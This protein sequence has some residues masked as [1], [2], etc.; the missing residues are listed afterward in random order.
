M[1]V[2]SL[3]RSLCGEG[4]VACIE[5]LDL[6]VNAEQTGE[7]FVWKLQE[8]SHRSFLTYLYEKVYFF[9]WF[10]SNCSTWA[11]TRIRLRVRSF[12][13]FQRQLINRLKCLSGIFNSRGKWQ[14]APLGQLNEQ[15]HVSWLSDSF[16][17]YR[18]CVADLRCCGESYSTLLPWRSSSKFT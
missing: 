12:Y 13:L 15:R 2:R 14:S 9:G 18:L 7:S 6:R 5:Q 3:K 16:H 10:Y 4:W 1:K 8:L 17:N 11:C